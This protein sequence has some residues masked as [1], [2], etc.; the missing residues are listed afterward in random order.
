LLSAGVF[1]GKRHAAIDARFDYPGDQIVERVVTRFNLRPQG[2]YLRDEWRASRNLRL[3]GEVQLQKIRFDFRSQYLSPETEPPDVTSESS[4]V[5]LPN[6]VADY[7]LSPRSGLRARYRRIFGTVDDFQLLRPNDTFLYS[8]LDIPGI[9]ILGRGETVDVEYDHTFA[10]ASFLRLGLLHHN[11]RRVNQ[12]GGGLNA[13]VRGVRAGYEGFLG[14]DTSFFLNLG[15]NDIDEAGTQSTLR[16]VSKFS[17]S[18]GLQYLNESGYFVQ[19]GVFYRSSQVKTQNPFRE[20]GGFAVW[21]LRV[22]KRWGLRRTLVLELNNAFDKSF[23][24]RS[25]RQSGR[26]LIMGATG[27]F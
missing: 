11:L 17:G 23:A 20:A 6:V 14:R 15:V 5:G 1:A 21:N 7:R 22:G 25:E 2:A 12:G 19:P 9:T 3:T 16:G 13:R 26:R 18:A 24:L 8:D 27:R 10:N 4:T